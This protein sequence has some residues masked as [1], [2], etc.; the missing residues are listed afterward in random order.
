MT[1]LSSPTAFGTKARVKQ[2][3][4]AQ[5]PAERHLNDVDA[6]SDFPENNRE[7][8]RECVCERERE[9]ERERARNIRCLQLENNSLSHIVSVLVILRSWRLNFCRFSLFH[10]TPFVFFCFLFPRFLSLYSFSSLYSTRK[11][12]SSLFLS[13]ICASKLRL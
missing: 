5:I 7:R 10:W 12:S 13:Q 2:Y 3:I 1:W 11:A 6:T 9:R 4:H 8:E